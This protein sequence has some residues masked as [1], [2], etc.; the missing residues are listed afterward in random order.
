MSLP[1]GVIRLTV[2]E[3]TLQRRAGQRI[4]EGQIVPFGVSIEH[5]GSLEAF[6]PSAFDATHPE[7][8]L[9]FWEHQEPVGRMTAL[10]ARDGGAWGTFL[11][12]Q[13]S[14]GDDLL[15]LAADGVVT[16]LSV[17]FVPDEWRFEGEVRVHTRVHLSE[18][19][20][21]TWPAYEGARISALRSRGGGAMTTERPAPE[22]VPAEPEGPD[23]DIDTP[24]DEPQ[25]IEKEEGR[26]QTRARSADAQLI[27]AIDELRQHLAFSRQPSS[28]APVPA[29]TG[30]TRASIELGRWA[31]AVLRA[32]EGDESARREVRALANNVTTDHPGLVPPQYRGEIIGIIDSRRYFLG[33]VRRLTDD[34][35]GMQIVVPRITQKP[36]VAEQ[37]AEKTEV[38]SR[39]V[40]TDTLP[41]NFKT[42]AGAGDISLQLLV[43]SSPSFLA[44]YMELLSEA[45]AQ[46]TDDVA[47]DTLVATPGVNTVAEIDPSDVTTFR[48]IGFTNT[49]SAVRRSPDTIWLSPAAAGAFLD[50]VSTGG[51]TMYPNLGPQGA[52]LGTA[53]MAGGIGQMDGL[54]AIVNPAQTVA[55][56]IGWSGG[57]VYA[58]DG[59]YTL[60][61]DNPALLGRD[62]AIAGLIAMAAWYPGAFTVF[63][64]LTPE[65]PAGTQAQAS[66]SKKS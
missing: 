36:L 57:F 26:V 34:G 22:P 44:L 46:V 47:V 66:S 60:T 61:A 30:G 50:S 41:M 40:T 37:T 58:E 21:V 2:E 45:Y 39:K 62:V 14:R 1:N 8:V 29:V 25:E 16:G 27:R 17:G 15:T 7:D 4:V 9:L 64:A 5:L 51:Q 6:A 18:V 38:A 52:G 56:I 32:Q 3:P 23:P 42:Y 53:S 28:Q 55:A 65:A 49:F 11:V 12:S 43:R 48:G 35:S 54:R 19:S 33:S 10:V 24:E 63:T 59:T 20:A 31:S 13:T